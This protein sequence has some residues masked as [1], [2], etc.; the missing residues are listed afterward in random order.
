[1]DQQTCTVIANMFINHVRKERG[2]LAKETARS[3]RI[4][5]T[6][7]LKDY[8]TNGQITDGIVQYIMNSTVSAS[9]LKKELFIIQRFMQF[10][11][12]M[13]HTKGDGYFF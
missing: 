9:T 11:W 10:L 4:V 6:K 2:K 3:Y 12:G 8:P 1:M 13:P 7:F 5:I